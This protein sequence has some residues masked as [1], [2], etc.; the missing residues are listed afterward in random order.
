MKTNEEYMLDKYLIDKCFTYAY[1]YTVYSVQGSSIDEHVIV[2]QIDH[3]HA[4]KTWCYVALSR[5]TN[6]NNIYIYKGKTN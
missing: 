2:H 4:T 5:A 1:A 3:G 6:F